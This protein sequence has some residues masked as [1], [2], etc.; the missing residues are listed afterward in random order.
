MKNLIIVSEWD[1]DTF[2]NRVAEL[3][4][5]GYTV[6]QESYRVTAE[7]DPETGQIIH[8]RTV[9]LYR[10]VEDTENLPSDS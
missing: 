6:R 9:E 5:Q 10:T 8:L 7:M 3:E 1:T 4:R 2:H